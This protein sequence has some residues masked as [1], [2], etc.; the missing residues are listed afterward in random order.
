MTRKLYSTAYCPYAWRTRI[1]LYEKQLP[2]EVFEVELKQKQ[3]EFLRVSPTGKVP[4]F[5]DGDTRIWESMVIN[6]YLEEKYPQPNLLGSTPEERAAVRTDV[7]DLNWYRSQPLAK[8]AAMLF[9]ERESRDELKIRRQ[10][11]KWV[12]YLDHLEARFAEHDWLSID[13]FSI[14]D[15]SLYT[16]VAIGESFRVGPAERHTHLRAWL[17]RMNRRPSVE[18]SR[19]Q[20]VPDIGAMLAP[21][22]L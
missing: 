9:Y 19:P 7:I 3:E 20:V 22:A 2:F 21:T 5:V 6:E 14:S 17:D 11:R 4:V 12:D 16:T 15:I 8:L 18:R 13:R 1:V 10:H